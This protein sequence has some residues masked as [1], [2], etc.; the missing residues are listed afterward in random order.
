M[1][2]HSYYCCRCEKNNIYSPF[3]IPIIRKH[4]MILYYNYNYYYKIYQTTSN[5]IPWNLEKLSLLDFIFNM[6][7]KVLG[8][9]VSII[10]YFYH[11]L[12][13]GL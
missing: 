1:H 5:Y 8:F 4:L 10:K 12:I 9:Y 7:T 6:M 11:L 13:L 2:L 3:Y